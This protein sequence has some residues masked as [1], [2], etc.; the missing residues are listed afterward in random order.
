MGCKKMTAAQG[1]H[2]SIRACP[3]LVRPV[4]WGAGIILGVADGVKERKRL[5]L[6]VRQEPF[7]ICRDRTI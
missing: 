3:K 2:L 1:V 6:V 4:H 7:F 5:L